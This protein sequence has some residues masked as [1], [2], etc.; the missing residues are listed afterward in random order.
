MTITSTQSKNPAS[1]FNMAVGRY[2]DT[3]T[4]AAFTLTVGFKA[5][6]VRIQNLNSSGFVRM[7][8]YEGMAA[9]SGV[10][11]A[12]TGD[13]SLITTLGITVAAK[14][15]L[16]GFDTDLLV[17]SEQLSWLAIG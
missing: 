16:V 7:E 1:V 2:L 15:I 13:Q 12:K 3:G 10:K 11:T 14:T 9:A 8:W 6:Y 5:R 4:V 17:T